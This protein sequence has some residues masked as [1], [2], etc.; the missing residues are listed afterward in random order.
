MSSAAP[1][2][3]R[4]RECGRIVGESQKR[5]RGS[6]A[7]GC[8]SSGPTQA[9]TRAPRAMS[10]K[11]KGNALRPTLHKIEA[12]K[13]NVQTRPYRQTKVCFN[14]AL[15]SNVADTTQIHAKACIV[16][17]WYSREIVIIIARRIRH[18]RNK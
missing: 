7:R 17:E 8:A 5:R 16:T 18:Q 9:Q 15:T 6:Y 2:G 3:S 4:D 11:K 12:G 1:R 14:L 13:N 10:L